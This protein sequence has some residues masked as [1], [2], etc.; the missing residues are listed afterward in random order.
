MPHLAGEIMD[1]QVVGAFLLGAAV[2]LI[3]NVTASPYGLSKFLTAPA[4]APAEFCAKLSFQVVSM[5]ASLLAAAYQL[6]GGAV[7]RSTAWV[8]IV[9]LAFPSGMHLN[10]SVSV[11][12]WTAGKLP[13]SAML[14]K[15]PAQAAAGIASAALISLA[16]SDLHS[17]IGAPLPVTTDLILAFLIEAAATALT[18]IMILTC[19]DTFAGPHPQSMV[20]ASLA[21]AIGFFTGG[22]TDV[23]TSG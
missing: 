10:P 7:G 12:F 5:T 16:P 14:A 19:A 23:S 13:F 18:M 11:S 15:L 9:I 6:D 2:M 3:F 8:L 1:D 20:V 17:A 21:I 22:C 4:S